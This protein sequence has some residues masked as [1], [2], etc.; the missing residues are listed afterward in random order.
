MFVARFDVVFRVFILRRV[1]GP[2]IGQLVVGRE[3]QREITKVRVCGLCGSC[4]IAKGRGKVFIEK[5]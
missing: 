4:T 3:M 1:I 5:N 2:I